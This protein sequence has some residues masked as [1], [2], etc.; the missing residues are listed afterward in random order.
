MP[1]TAAACLL[2][3]VALAPT[4]AQAQAFPSKPIRLV[5]PFPAGSATDS[6]ARSVGASVSAAIGQP[7]LVDNK[8][9]ADG[10]IAGSE[11]ARAAPDGYTLLMATNSRCRRCPH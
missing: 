5:V 11:V 1:F 8:A 4:A 7:V 2:A 6:I 9:G 3:L 10:A